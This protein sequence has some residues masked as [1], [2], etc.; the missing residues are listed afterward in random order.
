MMPSQ[1]ARRVV[2]VTHALLMAAVLLRNPSP[3]SV[4]LL[5]VLCT[6]LPGLIRGRPYT[7]AWASLLIAFFVA[8]YLSD[9][10]AVAGTRLSA[11]AIGSVAALE[12]VSLMMFVRWTAREKTLRATP[13]PAAQTAASDDALR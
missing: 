1:L 12:F 7:Y 13:A 2:L 3:V 6:P 8:G 10:F 5:L 11:F 4:I 9:G